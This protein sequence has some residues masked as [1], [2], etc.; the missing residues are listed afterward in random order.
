[1]LIVE[2]NVYTR[3]GK[4][5]KKDPVL[6]SP[7]SALGGGPGEDMGSFRPDPLSVLRGLVCWGWDH[8]SLRSPGD[9]MGLVQGPRRSLG[10][11]YLSQ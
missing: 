4:G 8:P 10:R 3:V 6:E 5:R 2:F 1:M 9:A 7:S 11:Q